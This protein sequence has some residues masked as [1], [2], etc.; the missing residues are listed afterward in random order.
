MN[1]KEISK[2]EN[3]TSS[4]LSVLKREAI[5]VIALFM[6][7]VIIFKIVFMREELFS[8]VKVVFGLFWLYLLPGFI[9]MYIWFDKFDIIERLIA[10]VV[11]GIA[12]VNL[13]SYYLTLINFD[14]KL[15]SIV[16]PIIIEI[17]VLLF[18]FFRKH[19]SK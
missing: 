5:I 2:K 9:T 3:H 13:I 7:F 17:I 8:I 14:I 11:L 15:Q 19:H 4:P 12:L 18:L 6:A 16:I 1:T 10:G